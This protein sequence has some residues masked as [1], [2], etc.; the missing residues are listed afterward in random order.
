MALEQHLSQEQKLIQQQQQ[1]LTAQQILQVRLLEMPLTQL[2]ENIKTELYENPALDSEQ[3]EDANLDVRTAD[4]DVG[5]ASDDDFLSD[6]NSF[7]N[8][9]SLDE[10]VA[11]FGNDT[12]AYEASFE[13]QTE[14][15]EREDALDSALNSIDSDDRL[16]TDYRSLS[17]SG[18]SSSEEQEE[19]VYGNE[20]SFYDKLMEQVSDEDLTNRDRAIIEY[21]IGSLDNDGLLRTDLT[22]ISDD[23]AI[24]HEVDASERDIEKVLRILQSFDPPGVGARSLQECLLLQIKRRDESPMKRLMY[25]AIR[26]HFDDFTKKHWDKLRS[27]LQVSEKEV[28]EVI[29]ELR[30]LNPRPGSSLGETM[31]RSI[32]QVTPD[33]IVDPPFQGRISFQL[34]NG[35]LPRIFISHD[36]EEQMEGY[37]KNQKSLNRMEKEAL[38]Y[39]K[40]KIERA[41]G[42]IEAIE[43]RR[44]TLTSTMRAIIDIQHR[45]FLEGDETELR[46]MTL[47]D[48]ADR[49]GLDIS[50]I[51][52][53]CNA[54]YAETPWGIFPLRHFF[55]SGLSFSDGDEEMSNRK[56]K[57]A[58]QDIIDGEDKKRPLSDQALAE[59]MKK[60]GFPIARRT[61]AKYR[62][63]MGIPVA[64]L[65]K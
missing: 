61:V 18:G 41:R 16:A 39:T 22:F 11:E 13:A 21:L 1:R 5:N 26:H 4:G 52:R 35:E 65:R 10:T 63:A 6:D 64:R 14:R 45:Y 15:E 20:V 38:L 31:G 3:P 49:V 55:S 57:A 60:I 37:M 7:E 59:A 24:Y 17:S 40:E 34:N 36:F 50:T 47:K 53:V 46:P 27:G 44:N 54:K 28:E 19:I 51:S 2:E 30:R 32:Q 56:I 43:K 25:K 12:D 42:Y 62:E 23:L 8:S 33:F 48:V 29:A 9:E 58:L